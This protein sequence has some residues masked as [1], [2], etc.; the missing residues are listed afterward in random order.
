MQLSSL[1]DYMW[2]EQTPYFPSFQKE[3]F[4]LENMMCYVSK[5]LS[6]KQICK[7]TEFMKTDQ[8]SNTII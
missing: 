7:S 5:L 2:K 3:H 4:S 8:V 1:I 6:E